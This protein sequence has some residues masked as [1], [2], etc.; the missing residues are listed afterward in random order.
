MHNFSANIEI[1]K[2]QKCCFTGGIF[3]KFQR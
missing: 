2:G 3:A 1:L